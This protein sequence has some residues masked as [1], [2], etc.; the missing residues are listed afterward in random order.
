VFED[1]NIVPAAN[2]NGSAPER[3]GAD[4]VEK[5]REMGLLDEKGMMI[6]PPP[7]R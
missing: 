1:M 6:W 3:A 7:G 5:L 2:L 4:T